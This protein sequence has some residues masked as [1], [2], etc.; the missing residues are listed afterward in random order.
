[1]KKPIDFSGN[2]VVLRLGPKRYAVY[3]HLQ[4]GT[5]AVKVGQRVR[6]GRV[7]AKLGN[8]GNTTAPHLH[9]VITDRP[10]FI[11]ATSLP[12]VIDR[13]T[14]QGDVT[15]EDLIAALSSG[16]PIPVIGPPR[17]Q[18]RTHPLVHSVSDYR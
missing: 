9:L 17:P 7:L 2:Q 14:L 8:S 15:P 12:F 13:Y 5:V 4:P 6:T 10:Q 18:S 3:A 16:Q 1:V 11:S